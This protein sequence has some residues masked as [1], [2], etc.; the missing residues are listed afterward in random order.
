MS[1]I[2]QALGV[3]HSAQQILKYLSQNNPQL[4]NQISQAISSGHTLDHILNFLE[5]SH[6]TIGK[7]IPEKRETE[8]NPNIFKEAQTSIHP[9]LK[10]AAQFAGNAAMAAGGAYALSRALP[11][12]L[13][14]LSGSPVQLPSPPN[15]GSAYSSSQNMTGIGAPQ[16]TQ[17]TQML[18]PQLKSA[19]SSQQP[20]VNAQPPLAAQPNIPQPAQPAQAQAI[21]INP[22]EILKKNNLTDKVDQLIASGNDAEGITG[23]LRKFHPDIVKKL[24]KE[25]QQDVENLINSYVV[26]KGK[27]SVPPLKSP[28]SS[29]NNPGKQPISSLKEMISPKIEKNVALPGESTVD[30]QKRLK[31]DY[32]EA[33]KIAKN[34]TVATPSGVGEVLEIRNGQAIVEI[35]G[36]KHKVAEDELLQSPIPEKDLADLYEDLLRSIEHE[37]GDQVSRSIN[38]VAYDPDNNSVIVTF[39][40]GDQYSYDDLD[41]EEQKESTELLG[42]RKTSGRSHIGAFEEG[43]KSPAGAKM[44]AFVKKLQSRRGGKG[45]EYA[46][47]YKP[48]YSRLGPAEEA[49]RIKYKPKPKKKT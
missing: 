34:S 32:G 8:K 43:T 45:N 19:V 15:S 49:H 23:Y 31:L 40:N 6:K 44:S 17:N 22:T 9:S 14:A 33:E 7:L 13:T 38:T 47:H 48:V 30:V 20:P 37:T 39:N 28:E 12:S 35:D 1:A 41:E 24:E 11:S 25:G 42:L 36:K 5:R 4:A 18:S 2:T 10:G 21:S 27:P 3:G 26:E 16:H 29:E 46:K